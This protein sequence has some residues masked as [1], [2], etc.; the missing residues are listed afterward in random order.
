MRLDEAIRLAA[1]RA[2]MDQLAHALKD[3]GRLGEF[4]V[5]IDMARLS[6]E[7]RRAFSSIHGGEQGARDALSAFNRHADMVRPGT[8]E[9]MA[10]AMARA[11]AEE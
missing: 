6:A 7:E 10:D 4:L 2:P 5:S 9:R 8:V 11:S 3:A 1:T